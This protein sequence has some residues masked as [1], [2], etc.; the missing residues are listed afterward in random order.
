MRRRR[1]SAER[2]VETCKQCHPAANVNFANYI[3][4]AD[5]SDREAYPQLYYVFWGMTWLLIGTFCVLR[6]AHHPVALP[7]DG[8]L[9]E[10]FAGVA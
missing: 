9:H 7:L 3:V 1:I 2:R 6:A 5:H 4:H 8:P 10:R